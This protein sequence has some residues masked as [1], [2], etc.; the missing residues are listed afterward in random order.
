MKKKEWIN[1]ELAKP[2]K[3]LGF[4]AISVKVA[5]KTP[6]GEGTGYYNHI[7]HDW[8]V[9]LSISD[10]LQ[11]YKNVTHWKFGIIIGAKAQK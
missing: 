1:A 10:E 3:A 11:S 8:L 4:K 2:E 5:V 7:D 6:L 9:E